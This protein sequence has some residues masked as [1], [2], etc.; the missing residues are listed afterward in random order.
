[1]Y[2]QQWREWSNPKQEFIFKCH[3]NFPQTNRFLLLYSTDQRS[4][5][6][7]LLYSTDGQ[8]LQVIGLLNSR[9]LFFSIN[10]FVFP[11]SPCTESNVNE[12]NDE[13]TNQEETIG[14]LMLKK[15]NKAEKSDLR[16]GLF[17][18]GLRVWVV[19]EDIQIPNQREKSS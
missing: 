12:K 8:F 3:L 17:G 14:R 6:N 9:C 19:T 10:S 13:S 15:A 7:F 18:S 11:F 16:S 5:V 2:L 1:M 4:F